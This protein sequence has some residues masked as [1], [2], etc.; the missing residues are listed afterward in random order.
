MEN[1]KKLDIFALRELFKEADKRISE[2]NSLDSFDTDKHVKEKTELVA[3]AILSLILKIFHK[4]DSN[5]EIIER[6]D[7]DLGIIAAPGETNSNYEFSKDG[8]T[9]TLDYSKP[10]EWVPTNVR[11]F[12]DN[13][14]WLLLER[15]LKAYDIDISR[16]KAVSDDLDISH[17][18]TIVIEVENAATYKIKETAKANTRDNIVINSEIYNQLCNNRVALFRDVAERIEHRIELEKVE[19]QTKE[20]I[21]KQTRRRTEDMAITIQE[22]VWDV[23]NRIGNEYQERGII[24]EVPEKL[25]VLG[26]KLGESK[27][28]HFLF[29]GD[30]LTISLNYSNNNDA[31]SYALSFEGNVDWNYLKQLLKQYCGIDI[32]HE[33][34]RQNADREHPAQNYDIVTIRAYGDEKRYGRNY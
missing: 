24:T 18:D 3:D 19:K 27:Q 9:I 23:L 10:D 17:P 28:S 12:A 2:K 15:I 30:M 8:L 16:N 34:Y 14:D 11:N 21:E 1:D 7:D 6:V 26:N 13:I 22:Y 4:A 5:K 20:F 29:T 32:E 25:G 33:V 31:D